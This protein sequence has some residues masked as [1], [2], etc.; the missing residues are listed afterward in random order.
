MTRAPIHA[1][2]VPYVSGPFRHAE[3]ARPAVLSPDQYPEVPVV[4]TWAFSLYVLVWFLEFGER[5]ALFGQI[6]L[7]FVLGALL[8]VAAGVSIAARDE[9]NQSRLTKYIC[10]YFLFLL[11]HLPLSQYFAHSWDAFVNWIVKF[12]CMA[13]FIYAFVRSPKTLR[14]FIAM[15]MIVFFKVGEEAFLGKITGSMVWQ[16]QGIM[17]LH[18][19][20]GLRLGHPNS[21]SGFGVCML[22]FLYYFLPVVQRK[23]RLFLAAIFVFA[24]TIIVF[25]G[26]RTGYLTSFALIAFLWARSTKKGRFLA[27]A[28]VVGAVGLPLVPPQYEARFVSAFVGEEAEGHS[29]EARI[30]LANDGWQLFLENPQGLGIYAFRY[31]LEDQLGKESYDPHNLYIQVLVDL[32]LP[33][34]IVFGL[35]MSALWFELRSTEA[36]LADSERR[37]RLALSGPA[38]P[39][40]A[41][42]RHLKDVRFMRATASAFLA[43][44]FARLVLGIFGHDLYEIYWWLA[45]GASIAVVNM[46][47]V[48]DLRTEALL[49]EKTS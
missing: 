5:V 18:G 1:P 36:A 24:V 12:A 32:G 27:A 48:S 40:E 10:A 3:V 16:N 37:L 6:R 45:A 44:I 2:A 25:T 31:A 43:F 17:R 35:F 29:K 38:V 15:L 14:I 23:A 11:V 49:A 33:G 20:Q 47:P 26:S 46:Q 22:P 13:L 9:A 42:V 30:G 21:L 39:S 34:A 7:E 19:T 8:S 28:L 41:L 4:L